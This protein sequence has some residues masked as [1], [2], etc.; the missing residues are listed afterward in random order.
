MGK[1]QGEGKLNKGRLLV[2][3]KFVV[4]G[5]HLDDFEWA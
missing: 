3:G 1:T 5:L 4:G 2:S